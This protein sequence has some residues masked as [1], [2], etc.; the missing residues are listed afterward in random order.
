VRSKNY[1]R[2]IFFIVKVW[3]GVF[4]VSPALWAGLSNTSQEINFNYR[5]ATPCRRGASL[6]LTDLAVELSP[7]LTSIHYSMHQF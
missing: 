3:T 4:C 2:G 6:D 1:V 7:Q 5:E